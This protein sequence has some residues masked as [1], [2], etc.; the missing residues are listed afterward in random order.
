LPVIGRS[1]TSI[2]DPLQHVDYPG[3]YTTV[4]LLTSEKQPSERFKASFP[5]KDLVARTTSYG[6]ILKSSAIVGGSQIVNVGVGI[7]RTKAMALLLGPAGFGL[8]GP[9]NSILDLTQNIA[10]IGVNSSGV[11]QI[12]QAVGSGDQDRVGRTVA[13]LRRTSVI[14]GL[15]GSLA[16]LSFCRPISVFTFGSEKYAKGVAALSLGVFF[17]LVSGGQG[18]LIQGMRRVTDLAKMTVC[19]S[20]FGAVIGIAL[21]FV[22][23]ERGIVPYVIAVAATGIF[24]SWWYSRKIQIKTSLLTFSD[25]RCEAS[26]LLKLGFAFMIS[27]MTTLGVAYGVRVIILHKL[28]L[29]ATGLYQSAW[30]LGGLYVSFILQAMA[31]DFYP[32]LTGSIS[33]HAIANRLVNEQAS[34]GLLMAG[35][36]AIATLTA[37]PI[38]TSVLYS[39]HFG[40]AVPI[41]RWICLGAALQVISWPMG[42]I[43]IAKG[44]QNFFILSEV[45]WGVTS[46]ALAWF[47][48]ARF[49]ISGS[50]MAFFGSYIFHAI[51]TYV[52][53]SWLSGFRWSTDNIRIAAIYLGLTGATFSIK[54]L[55]PGY[56]NVAIGITATL[57]ATSYS[58]YTMARLLPAD[59]I[60]RPVQ[61]LLRMFRNK[62]KFVEENCARYV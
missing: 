11:R 58:I 16:L 40:A 3:D 60:P 48:I 36:G 43:I 5:S 35:P 17:K 62:G 59:E 38:I 22:F 24:T 21:V 47:C 46:L 53:V 52:I 27:S 12:A 13:V 30:T 20:V 34:V 6:Q 23:R 41:L 55:L 54:Y 7:V 14:L 50:G 4:E 19:G 29:Q 1:Q 32:R 37:A 44:K 9:Y 18:A 42:F 25:L 28:G 39:A 31:A 33:N 51:M 56:L 10:G 49:G 61:H 57:F 45:A 2:T 26:A 15:L 8:A